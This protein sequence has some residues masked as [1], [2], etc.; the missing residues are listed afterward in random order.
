ML[1]EIPMQKLNNA[2][3]FK[4]TIQRKYINVSY[5][6]KPKFPFAVCYSSSIKDY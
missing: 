4:A 6:V 5:L 3:Y 2:H 1:L